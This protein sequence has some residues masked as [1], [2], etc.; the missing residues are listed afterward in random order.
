MKFLK[1]LAVLAILGGL[2]FAF[3]PKPKGA[4]RVAS[5]AF[6]AKAEKR[7][8]RETVEAAGFVRAVSTSVRPSRPPASSARSSTATS[9]PRSAASCRSSTSRPVTW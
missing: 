4:G 6:E 5:A 8:I 7:D 3:W 1:P 2:T 9:A